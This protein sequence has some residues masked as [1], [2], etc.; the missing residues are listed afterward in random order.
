MISPDSLLLCFCSR[1]ILLPYLTYLMSFPPSF[2]FS[3]FHLWIQTWFISLD[4]DTNPICLDIGLLS[5]HAHINGTHPSLP[6]AFVS[7]VFL[8]IPLINALN[9]PLLVTRCNVI[10]YNFFSTFRSLSFGRLV[11]SLWSSSFIGIIIAFTLWTN[12]YNN[13]E[14]TVSPLFSCA[15]IEI[16]TS[17]WPWQTV[18]TVKCWSSR[19]LKSKMRGLT[20][21]KVSSWGRTQLRL[22]SP[23]R[24]L[25]CDWYLLFVFNF[26]ILLF[27]VLWEVVRPHD[28]L[29]PILCYVPSILLNLLNLPQS[30]RPRTLVPWKQENPRYTQLYINSA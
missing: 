14:T 30:L 13:D 21:V 17:P 27:S 15:S 20:N 2:L 26:F 6:V 16:M 1:V 18:G 24:S 3:L 9:S 8:Y 23:F 5:R 28:S 7:F 22:K 11:L 10:M 4:V 29:P 12:D 25:V 19:I